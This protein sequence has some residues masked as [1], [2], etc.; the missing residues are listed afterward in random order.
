MAVDAHSLMYGSSD[1][2]TQVQGTV[3]YRTLIHTPLQL[4]LVQ[5][6]SAAPMAVN[7]LVAKLT[8]WV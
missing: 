1:T 8:I 3:A 5:T 6:Q 4:Q 2:A 7:G